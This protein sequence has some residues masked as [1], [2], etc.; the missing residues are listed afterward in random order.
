MK[1]TCKDTTEVKLIFFSVH[2]LMTGADQRKESADEVGVIHNRR[3]N[4]KYFLFF[5]QK[6][7]FDFNTGLYQSEK[8]RETAFDLGEEWAAKNF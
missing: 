3:R 2:D 4:L 6:I 8:N 7:H 5:H 1:A